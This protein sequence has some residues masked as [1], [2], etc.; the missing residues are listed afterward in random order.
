MSLSF[1][2]VDTGDMNDIPPDAPPGAWEATLEVKLKVSSKESLP[3]L[4]LEWH[5]A[6]ALT[7]GNEAF[8]GGRV[9][10]FITFCPKGH[11][12]AKMNKLRL[13]EVGKALEITI[14]NQ[15][16]WASEEDFSQLLRAM[17]GARAKIWTGNQTNVETGEVR[18]RVYYA[19]PKGQRETIG[20]GE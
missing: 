20:A 4:V 3:M 11:K 8:I 17:N 14:P 7:E 15:T 10:D 12:A 18:T 1:A 5:L 6:E 19:A 16:R 2:P 13:Q 9:S